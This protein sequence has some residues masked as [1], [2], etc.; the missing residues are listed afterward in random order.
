MIQNVNHKEQQVKQWAKDYWS[1]QDWS[2]PAC[3]MA[4]EHGVKPSTIQSIAKTLGI[5]MVR[6]NGSGR[7]A[8]LWGG[9]DWTKQDATIAREVNRSRE[10]VRQVRRRLGLAPSG[11]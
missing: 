3:D 6:K 7:P 5:K 9:V 8:A 4:L 10:R 11:K 2:K 1:K